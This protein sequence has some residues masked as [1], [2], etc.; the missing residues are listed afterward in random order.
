MKNILAIQLSSSFFGEDEIYKQQKKHYELLGADTK[1]FL[2]IPLWI[3]LAKN[4][5]IFEKFDYIIVKS[6]KELMLAIKAHS[7]DI[8]LASIM[9]CT[10]KKWELA[11]S[12]FKNTKFIIGGYDIEGLASNNVTVLKDIMD[13]HTV[14]YGGPDPSPGIDYSIFKEKAVP[15]L[16]LSTGCSHQCKF[17]TIDNQV[18]PRSINSI[19]GQVNSFKDLTFEYIY[20]DDKTFG[21]ASTYKML[22]PLYDEICTWN[23]QFKG[24]IIQTTTSMFDHKIARQ[25]KALHIEY[26]ELGIEIYDNEILRQYNKPSNET[27]IN[28]SFALAYIYDIKLIPNILVGI[29][30]ATR[31]IYIKTLAL[32]IEHKPLLAFVNIFPLAIYKD[33]ILSEETGIVFGD[34]NNLNKSFLDA[35]RKETMNEMINEL[36]TLNKELLNKRKYNKKEM[37]GMSNM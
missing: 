34:E 6:F 8:I 5:V 32:L 29:P 23:N 2:E 10:R 24:F 26:V 3:A 33:T 7:N 35:L 15:R 9:S 25:C 13:L 27:L 18:V 17:C 14:L 11:F 21:Q 1:D 37:Y 12:Y 28:N 16:Q 30:E 22:S 19:M 31:D 20:I 36:L 4:Q